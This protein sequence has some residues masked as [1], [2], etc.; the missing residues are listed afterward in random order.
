[1]GKNDVVVCT[2][3]NTRKQGSIELKKNWVGT[4]GRRP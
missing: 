1:M 2:F 3:T 4:K